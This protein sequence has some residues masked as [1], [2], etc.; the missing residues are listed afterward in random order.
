MDTAIEWNFKRSGTNT[1]RKR[2]MSAVRVVDQ[3]NA[4]LGYD[5]GTI[6]HGPGTTTDAIL[7]DPVWRRR[8]LASR[9]EGQAGL[10]R[11]L[12]QYWAESDAEDQ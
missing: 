8:L 2:R 9:Q 5:V 11:P 4:I 3:V 1:V 12:E 7:N 10:S 6:A